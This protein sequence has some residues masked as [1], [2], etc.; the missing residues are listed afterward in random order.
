MVLILYTTL[1]REGGAQFQSVAQTMAA[2]ISAS[3]KNVRLVRVESK[4]EAVQQLVES[5]VLGIQEFHFIGHSGLYG[6]MFGTIARPEQLSPY[7]WRS[8]RLSFQHDAVAFFHCCRSARWFAPFFA[9]TFGVTSFGYYWYTTFSESKERFLVPKPWHHAR[10]PLYVFGCPGKK[11]HGILGSLGKY[12]GFVRPEKP[13]RFLP[14]QSN[15]AERYDGVAKQYARVFN[16]IEVRRAEIEWFSHRLHQ[17]FPKR[18]PDV[19]DIG[20]GSGSM[21]DHF[22]HRL[23]SALGI[24]ISKGMLVQA[25]RKLS[26]HSHISLAQVSEPVIPAADNQFDLVMSMLSF[27][28]L[29]WDPLMA[30]FQ[31]VL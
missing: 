18:K 22:A 15:G 30:E 6:P 29:D 25:E 7:E 16:N 19:L 17:L 11:S 24:D 2:S 26:R 31:R 13:K 9:R 12:T 10:K 20:C 28:Y 21:L 1:Y 4:K 27:R 23:N 8:L 14:V 3:G 5:S